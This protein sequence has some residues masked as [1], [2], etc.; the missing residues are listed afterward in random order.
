MIYVM[1]FCGLVCFL[2]FNLVRLMLIGWTPFNCLSPYIEICVFC[3]L[4]I[5]LFVYSSQNQ[6]MPSVVKSFV[7]GFWFDFVFVVLRLNAH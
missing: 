3:C 7:C 1:E 2:L 4:F 6:S 5:D